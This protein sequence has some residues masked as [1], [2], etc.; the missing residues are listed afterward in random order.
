MCAEDTIPL[1]SSEV[2]CTLSNHL[3]CFLM[4]LTLFLQL[5]ILKHGSLPVEF[6][7][8]HPSE[9]A[10]NVLQHLRYQSLATSCRGPIGPNTSG[11]TGTSLPSTFMLISVKQLSEFQKMGTYEIVYNQKIY[12]MALECS[13]ALRYQNQSLST[14]P[15][16]ASLPLSLPL[17][18]TLSLLPQSPSLTISKPSISLSVGLIPS[19]CGEISFLGKCDGFDEKWSPTDPG[20]HHSSLAGKTLLLSFDSHI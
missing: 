7:W 8:V 10:V 20:L 17:T 13:Q 15:P 11:V 12:N 6:F 4:L 19:Y 16:P 5:P 2:S 18:L 9:S 3:R 1:T 14:H